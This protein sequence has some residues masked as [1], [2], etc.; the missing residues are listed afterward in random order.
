MSTSVRKENRWRRTLQGINDSV[1]DRRREIEAAVMVR[2]PRPQVEP[3]V[4]KNSATRR[5]VRVWM[6][7]NAHEYDCATRLAE[8]ANVVFDLPGGG[9]DDE[10][11]WV[12]EEAALA[13]GA[14]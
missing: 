9:L 7:N 13:R 12:W 6:R 10:T 2:A 1:S 4:A 8:A 11:H 14:E 3:P 5:Q